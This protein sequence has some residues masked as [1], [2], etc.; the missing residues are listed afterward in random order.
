MHHVHLVRLR[1][2]VYGH[3]ISCQ[4]FSDVLTLLALS[5]QIRAWSYH[6]FVRKG[7]NCVPAAIAFV[8]LSFKM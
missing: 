6:V 8:K 5:F 1:R 7:Q 2:N 3:A 4:E